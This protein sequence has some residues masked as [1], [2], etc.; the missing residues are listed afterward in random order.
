MNSFNK[1]RDLGQFLTAASFMQAM[2]IT[3]RQPSGASFDVKIDKDDSV[4]ALKAAIAA[5]TKV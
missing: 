5:H 4:V 1:R 2:D 3:V